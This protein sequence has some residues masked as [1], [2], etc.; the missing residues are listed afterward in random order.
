MVFSQ[1]VGGMWDEDVDCIV[2]E[3]SQ[4][5]HYAPKTISDC[6]VHFIVVAVDFKVTTTAVSVTSPVINRMLLRM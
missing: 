4:R 1:Q 6:A 5:V 3:P 2:C